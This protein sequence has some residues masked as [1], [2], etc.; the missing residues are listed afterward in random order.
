[1]LLQ[2]LLLAAAW[3]ADDDGACDSQTTPC[4]LWYVQQVRDL[5]GEAF[6]RFMRE[7]YEN[8]HARIR[9]SALQPSTVPD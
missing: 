1:M 4:Y 9:R 3:I 5:T 8:I 2:D 7:L 6:S